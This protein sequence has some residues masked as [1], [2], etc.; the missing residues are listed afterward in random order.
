MRRYVRR[1]GWVTL[2]WCAADRIRREEELEAFVVRGWRAISLIHVAAADPFRSR[3]HANL[4]SRAIIADCRTDGVRAVAI[5]ITWL[6]R[7]ADARTGARMNTVVPVVVMNC[8]RAAPAAIVWLERVVIPKITSVSAPN[9]DS[10]TG[11]AI[12]PY[13]RSVRIA[14]SWFNCVRRDRL[15]HF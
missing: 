6:Q 10:L 13:L 15:I 12:S 2:S 1:F 7:V 11:V 3:S 8:G 5:V 9:H 4:I 14:D